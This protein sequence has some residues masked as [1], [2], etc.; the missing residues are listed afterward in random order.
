MKI[1]I[2][3]LL[4]LV[5]F[6][7][8]QNVHSQVSDSIPNHETFTID[9]KILKEKRVINVWLPTEYQ[10][11]LDSFPVLY[12]ADGGIKEDFPHLA[13]TLASLI[14]QQK[15]PPIILVGIE[16]TQRRRD[17]TGPTTVEY[18]K[19]I[20]PIVGQSSAFRNFIRDELF[21]EIEKK[22]RVTSSKSII[23]ESLAGLFVV[24]TWLNTPEMFDNYI[25]F[26]PSL[27]W[28]NHD[29]VNRAAELLA[30]QS[31]QP[32]KI[33][34]TS[35]KA[36]DIKKHTAALAKTLISKKLNHI[37]WNYIRSPKETHATIFRATKENALKW[38]F[39]TEVNQ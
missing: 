13:N 21:T 19:S 22:Y 17:L 31:T 4:M 34:F 36:K 18:D 29:L 23:G 3:V 6:I 33:W 32:T 30:K 12:M 26:D 24:E 20:A 27:W 10:E 38:T 2:S 7:S 14:E 25:A 37:H 11:K 28:N 16:N 8:T 35:S 15:I 39:G 5:G 1:K 9:S